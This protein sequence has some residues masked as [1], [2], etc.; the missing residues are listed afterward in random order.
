[1]NKSVLDF[2][3]ISKLKIKVMLLSTVTSISS[4]TI[5]IA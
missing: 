2:E 3:Y 5:A 1:M 4:V